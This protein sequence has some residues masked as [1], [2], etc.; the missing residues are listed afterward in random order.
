MSKRLPAEFPPVRHRL[1]K[2]Y[3]ISTEGS[4]R[5]KLTRL[6]MNKKLADSRTFFNLVRLERYSELETTGVLT[7][8]IRLVCS[9]LTR[10]EKNRQ[11]AV[12]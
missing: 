12:D 7:R 6:E 10:L 1:T 5:S 3:Y 2:H 8:E 9:R 11:T 4:A